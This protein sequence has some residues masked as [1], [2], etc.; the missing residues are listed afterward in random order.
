MRRS[1]DGVCGL[2]NLATLNHSLA[3]TA[4]E[5]LAKVPGVSVINDS[6]FN[7]FT[8][9]LSKEARPVIRTLA[10]RGVLGGVSLG[11]LYPGEDSLAN[12]LVVAVTETT[13]IED[14]QALATALTEVL[15]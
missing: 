7:E 11:R 12:G 1:L 10:E 8:L 14:I 5:R 9:K 13:T 4:A 15:A 2:R 3:V 6:F